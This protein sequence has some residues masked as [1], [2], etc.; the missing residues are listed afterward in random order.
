VRTSA[1]F[2]LANHSIAVPL[3]HRHVQHQHL[4]IANLIN[5]VESCSMELDLV[6]IS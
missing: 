1:L 2:S 5:K 4:L 3:A 6:A